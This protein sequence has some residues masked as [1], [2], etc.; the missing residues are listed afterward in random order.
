MLPSGER[1]FSRSDRD[2]ESV[3]Y[4]SHARVVSDVHWLFKVEHTEIFKLSTN[5]DSMVH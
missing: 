2:V 4:F 3:G 5:V 1:V